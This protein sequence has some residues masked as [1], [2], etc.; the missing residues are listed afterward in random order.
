MTVDDLEQVLEDKWVEWRIEGLKDEL[1]EECE[2]RVVSEIGKQ[3][4]LDEY[5]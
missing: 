3:S 5:V 2:E 4:Q 1:R